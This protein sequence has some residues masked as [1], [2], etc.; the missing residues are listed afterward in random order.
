MRTTI[1]TKKDQIIFNNTDMII[2]DTFNCGQCFRWNKSEDEYVGVVN[3]KIVIAKQIENGFTLEGDHVD[4][5]IDFWI[6]YFDL[7]FN[8]S[9][10]EK[11]VIKYPYAYE[12]YIKGK[13]IHILKQDPWEVIVSFIISAN[14]NI[15]R[16]KGI[17]E[18]L[19]ERYGKEIRY[20]GITSHSFPSVNDITAASVEDLQF[21][22]SGY[23]DKYLLRLFNNK[24]MDFYSF[25]KYN[26]DELCKE[27][28]KIKGIGPKVANC[29]MLF[30]FSRYSSFPKDVWIKR[31]IQEHFGNDFDE[32]ELGQY[33]GIIQQYLFHNA[34]NHSK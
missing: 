28:L 32:R 10:I 23:R 30:G 21:L 20:K 26:D 25:N 12:S 7:K 13:G 14:N 27:L 29:I 15:G 9:I 6:N 19:C 31:V 4:N 2:D 18:K 17:I 33:A 11:D 22:H 5:D 8:Y 34:R 24:D 16:I 3:S 1:E